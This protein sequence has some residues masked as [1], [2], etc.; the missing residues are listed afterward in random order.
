MNIEGRLL[1]FMSSELQC[2]LDSPESQLIESGAIDSLGLLQ[3]VGFVENEFGVEIMDEE[4]V[5]G[6]FQTVGAIAELVRTKLEVEDA[7]R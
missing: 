7:A 2:S 1:D 3:I 5:P 6:H 4:L